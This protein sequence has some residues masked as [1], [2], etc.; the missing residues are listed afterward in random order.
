MRSLWIFPEFLGPSVFDIKNKRG[1]TRN[2]SIANVRQNYFGQTESLENILKEHPLN[3]TQRQ[4]LIQIIEERKNYI[5]CRF[6]VEMTKS[7]KIDDGAPRCTQCNC[8]I[9]NSF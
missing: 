6:C 5:F 9:P 2:M 4:A 3:E 1:K 8:R 7:E